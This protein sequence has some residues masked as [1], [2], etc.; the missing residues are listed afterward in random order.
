MTHYRKPPL[1]IQEQLDL[2]QQR[3]LAIGDAANAKR[4]L[5]LPPHGLSLHTACAR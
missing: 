5:Q 4:Y 3:G 2:L 1:S